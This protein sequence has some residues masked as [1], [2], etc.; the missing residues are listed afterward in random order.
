MKW[1]YASLAYD[2]VINRRT[3][4]ITTFALGVSNALFVDFSVRD[5]LNFAK[6]DRLI[7]LD[8]FGSRLYLTRVTAA[9]LR[10]HLLNMNVVLNI[11][12]MTSSNGNTFRVT[13]PLCGEFT[14][15]RWIPF[16]KASDVELWCIL[17]S[18]PEQTLEQTIE[19]LMIWEAIVTVPIMT[20]L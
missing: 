17:S 16:T 4:N 13:G 20:S 9:G 6:N 3:T 1:T 8:S 2:Y 12:M 19:R 18:A 5:T 14:G 7:H 10:W 11:Y 15:H